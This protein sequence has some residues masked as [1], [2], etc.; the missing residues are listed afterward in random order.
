[1]F[2]KENFGVITRFVLTLV[3]LGLTI[4]WLAVVASLLGVGPTND[5]AGKLLFDP[6]QR[7]KDILLA[8]MP[9]PTVAL[10]YWFGA[11][12]KQEAEKKAD[13]AEQ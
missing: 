4:W 8:V 6:F 12:G 5:K 3:L 13:K 1:M 2:V 11:A 9:L 7:S 10:G